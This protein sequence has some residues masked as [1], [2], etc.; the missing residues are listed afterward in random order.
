MPEIRREQDRGI[1]A[2]VLERL[3]EIAGKSGKDLLKSVTSSFLSNL[4]SALDRM[5]KAFDERD[6]SDLEFAAHSLVGS[7][8][9]V[10]ALHLSTLCRRLEELTRQGEPELAAGCF[11]EIEQECRRVERELREIAQ[12]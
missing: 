9:M 10:G 6:S 5:R 7:S 1:D 2:Q 11:H 12:V 4:P 3:G 8:G